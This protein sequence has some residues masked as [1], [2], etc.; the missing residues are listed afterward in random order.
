MNKVLNIL[1][2]SSQLQL[3]S[4]KKYEVFYISNYPVDC[5]NIKLS[6]KYKKQMHRFCPVAEFQEK[7]KPD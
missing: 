5:I 7:K 3:A 1:S 2:L 4:K 6:M